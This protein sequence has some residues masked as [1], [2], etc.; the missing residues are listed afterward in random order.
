MKTNEANQKVKKEHLAKRAY[1]Y[2]RQSSIRQVHENQESTKRQY[3]LRQRAITLGWPD[4]R[5]VVIDT[6]LGQSAAGEADRKGFQ[7]LVSEVGLGKAGIVMGLE[8][9]RLARRCSD[10]HR[11]IEICAFTSTLLLDEDG[12]YD[13]S[14][15]ND[16]LILGLKGT[17]SEAEVHV[18]RSRLQG[19][20]L[21][22]AKRGELKLP[23]PVGFIYDDEDNVVL[24][25]D[26][27]VQQSIRF[28]FDT[29]QK[30]GSAR[31]TVKTFYELGLTFPKRIRHGPC[32][33]DVIWKPL[34]DGRINN[35]LHNP[36]YAGAY[37]YGRRQ[38]V[39]GSDGKKTLKGMPREKWIALITDAH[40]G[41]ISWNTF[42]RIQK[43]LEENSKAQPEI[44]RAHV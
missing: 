19:G 39:M 17:M 13:P 7:T 35:V 41:Y 37:S 8:V 30:K 3:A 25:P 4:D 44:G 34:T 24:D 43:K 38:E 42:E 6:D 15:F 40:E 23:L 33:N 12:I 36:H 26:Q 29:F 5:I 11:L 32:K 27:Q 10:W 16:R 2:I 21:N 14:V 31:M 1:L 20:L 28:L 22:K 18:I 9:S